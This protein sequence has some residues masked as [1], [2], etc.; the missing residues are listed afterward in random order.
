M[1]SPLQPEYLL[2]LLPPLE[3]TLLF[4]FHFLFWLPLLSG[5]FAL[6]GQQ[7]GEHLKVAFS[8]QMSYFSVSLSFCFRSWVSFFC[9]ELKQQILRKV[10]RFFA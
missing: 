4:Q 9:K 8:Q 6:D 3:N 10:W 5:G 2:S 7:S 1:H